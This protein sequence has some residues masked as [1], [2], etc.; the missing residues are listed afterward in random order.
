MVFRGAT[1][2]RV[3]AAEVI[4]EVLR[5]RSLSAL[6]PKYAQ[7]LK[8]SDQPLFKAL[9]FG[10]LRWYPQIEI[11][12]QQL[13]DK[14]L[15]QKE[16][17]LQALIACGIYQLLYMRIAEHAVINETVAGTKKLNRQWAKGFVNAVLRKV[18]RQQQSIMEQHQQNQV[19]HQAH[20]R[21]LIDELQ[22]DWP[23]A[24]AEQIMTA[25]NQP[26]PMTLRVNSQRCSREDYLQR[27]ADLG[28][29]AR[30]AHYSPQGLVLEKAVDVSDLPGFK[31]GLVS[32]QDEAAQLAAS[33]LAL[34][35]GQRVLDACCAPGGKTCHIAEL[36]PQLNSLIAIDLEE[37]RLKRTRENLQRLGLTA[38]LL[39]IDVGN[40]DQWWDGQCFDRILLDA[41]CSASGVIRRHPDIKLLRKGADIDKLSAI[42]CYLLNKVWKTLSDG[43]ILVYA[44]CS[45]FQREND[46]VIGQFLASNCDAKIMPIG[47]DWGYATDYGRQLLPTE[48]GSDGFYYAR[49]QKSG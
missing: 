43:G 14:P 46:Q 28:M 27:L 12:L 41:P 15:K 38:Q 8:P 24:V 21:W 20:P 44:T 6:L 26:A 11:I 2:V 40:I 42:Q 4:A 49:L 7:Q 25:N 13:I 5:G 32:V 31:Q 34:Q 47:G 35:A 45:V 23:S 10:T 18:Q 16:L 30:A 29:V 33:L 1:D 9:C 48:N 36:Q 22:K 17:P 39:A 3:A 37:E 19:F